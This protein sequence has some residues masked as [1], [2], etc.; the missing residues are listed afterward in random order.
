MVST[1]EFLQRL[2]QFVQQEADEQHCVLQLQW[3]RQIQE[4]VVRGWAIEG[5]RGEQFKN[6]IARLVCATNASRFRE[7][8]LVIL[9]RGNPYDE[10][11]QHCELQYD[12][13]TDLD[14]SVIR[15]NEVFFSATPNGWINKTYTGDNFLIRANLS[16]HGWSPGI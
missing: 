7:G 15:G 4:R 11:A 13:E 6:G 5:L 16:I 14:I 12:G 3:S 2:R 1:T 10:N 8:D 9:H